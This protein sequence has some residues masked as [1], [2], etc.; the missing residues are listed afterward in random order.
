MFFLKLTGNIKRNEPITSTWYLSNLGLV[1]LFSLCN[2]LGSDA[3]ILRPDVPQRRRQVRF[4]HVH[5]D[6]D[7]TLLHLTLQLMDLLQEDKEEG[8]QL[9]PSTC[10]G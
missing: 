8:L 10:G 5:L 9:R 4:G 2:V 1:P 7:L 3:L 6:L